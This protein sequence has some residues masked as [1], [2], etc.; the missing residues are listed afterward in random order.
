MGLKV[1]QTL[2]WR[3]A[4][5]A[6][7]AAHVA[8]LPASLVQFPA[9]CHRLN[10]ISLLSTLLLVMVIVTQEVRGQEQPPGVEDEPVMCEED[11]DCL[12]PGDMCCFDLSNLTLSS[13]SQV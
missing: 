9:L 2:D 12:S 1:C 3:E 4:S 11:R 5:C 7:L 13:A 6:L 8:P 10:M